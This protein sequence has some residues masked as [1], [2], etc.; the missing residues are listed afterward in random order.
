MR[1]V[2]RPGQIDEG[3]GQRRRRDG[4]PQIAGRLG[5]LARREH[6]RR[7][8]RR[9]DRRQA[10]PAPRRSGI[11]ERP[12]ARRERRDGEERGEARMRDA[13][14]ERPAAASAAALTERGRTAS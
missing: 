8:Q 13:R 12:A 11:G 5:G 14:P 4:Q 2:E 7:G 6:R 9:H 10:A 1:V 3:P